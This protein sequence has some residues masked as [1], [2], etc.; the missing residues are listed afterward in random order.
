MIVDSPHR[1]IFFARIHFDNRKTLIYVG[2]EMRLRFNFRPFRKDWD[3][4]VVAGRGN[5][6]YPSRDLYR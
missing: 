6:F 4:I 5:S 1:A 3:F 2:T